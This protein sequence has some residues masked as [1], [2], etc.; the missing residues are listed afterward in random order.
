MKRFRIRVWCM[1]ASYSGYVYAS[2]ANEAISNLRAEYRRKRDD[3][4]GWS[5]TARE[6]DEDEED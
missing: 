2:C 4:A 3:R 6:A 1:T 5:I